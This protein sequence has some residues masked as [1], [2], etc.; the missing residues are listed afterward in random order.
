MVPPAR[1]IGVRDAAHRVEADEPEV[2]ESLECGIN[3]VRGDQGKVPEDE[4]PELVCVRDQAP[5]VVG[6]GD[7]ARPEAELAIRELADL[8]VL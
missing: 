8:A 7:Q 4:K 6:L 3:V 1:Q 2:G 5:L